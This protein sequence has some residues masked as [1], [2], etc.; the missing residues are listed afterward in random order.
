MT[1]LNKVIGDSNGAAS[2]ATMHAFRAFRHFP[3][4]MQS[5][6]AIETL[7]STNAIST[8]SANVK[9]N[10]KHQEKLR[11]IKLKSTHKLESLTHSAYSE[12]N[13]I[14]NVKM[15]L[16]K[17][18]AKLREEAAAERPRMREKNSNPLKSAQKKLQK[19]S[20]K[21]GKF[22]ILLTI[23]YLFN[24]ISSY[25]ATFYSTDKLRTTDDLAGFKGGP[26]LTLTEF[27][28][29]L[30]RCLNVNLSS[31]EVNA[32][33]VSMDVDNSKTIDGVEFTRYFLRLGN[34]ARANIRL[35]AAKIAEEQRRLDEE[36]RIEEEIK[37]AQ[38]EAAQVGDFTEEE[39]DLAMLKLAEQAHLYDEKSFID[40]IFLQYFE[41]FLTPYEFKMQLSKSFHI[42]LSSAEL[43]A[44]VKR[45]GTRDGKYCIDGQ[46]FCI[47]FLQ[48]HQKEI[49]RH[50]RDME[51]TFRLKKL[52]ADRAKQLDIQLFPRALGR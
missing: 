7:T 13:A 18:R 2:N 8:S 1:S 33:F 27:E 26:G 30:K 24:L 31:E 40:Q 44:L 34:E 48:I 32:L 51:K 16:L 38:F 29:Q 45:F 20:L 12:I 41:C 37:Q 46:A 15:M 50:D 43:G 17:E 19:V 6:S 23:H 3:G 25:H 49:L 21:Y 11:P 28:T 5:V 52:L 35:Q 47:Q 39:A 14:R 36:R 4:L 9:A 42:T 10:R 22:L